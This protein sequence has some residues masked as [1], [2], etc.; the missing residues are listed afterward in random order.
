MRADPH[1]VVTHRPTC[2]SRCG[3]EFASDAGFVGVSAR[4]VFDLP[5]GI[6]LRVVEHRVTSLACPCGTVTQALAP[7]KVTAQ[8]QYGPRITAVACY[9]ADQH[10]VPVARAAHI[11]TDLCGAPISTGTI[12]TMRT[13]VATTLTDRFAA[14]AKNALAQADVLHVDET[15]FKIGG[16]LTWMH[17]ASTPTLT[18]I[19]P[20]PKRGRAAMDDIGILATFTGVLVHDAWAPYD[21]LPTVTGHQL[22]AAHLLRELQAVTDH[23]AHPEGQW[24]WADQAATA[25][26]AIIHNPATVDRNQ[27]LITAAIATADRFDPD[28][29]GKLGR[30]HAALRKR[31]HTR[32]NDYLRFT[33]DPTI[34]PTNNP[35]EQEIRMIKIKQKI[36]GGLRTL[37]GA[38]RFTTI[39]SYLATTRKHGLNP[40]TA[41][42]SAATGTP[43]LPTTP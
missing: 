40:L 7:P 12:E 30:K 9:L 31:L 38:T 41:L 29:P 34:P 42:T 36:S 14:A 17:S 22:C 15:G 13:R 18:W 4:Q 37:D 24:C 19:A 27:P 5:E 43:W 11:L 6:D 20:H 1:E 8:V 33:T 16:K 23:H 35:A 32:L 2:C 28:L 3:L 10:H 25:L 26:T 21:T 39:R